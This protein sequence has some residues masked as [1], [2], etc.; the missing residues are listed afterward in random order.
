MRRILTAS[1]MLLS[2]A[3]LRADDR[4]V[5]FD[6]T[7]DFA[8]VKTFAIHETKVTSSR[9]ELSNALFARQI[10]DAVRQALVTKGLKE[11]SD[12]PDVVVET[13]VTGID[14][15]IGTAG[16]AN[17]QPPNAPPSRFGPVAF[18]E[19]T[20]VVDLMMG[21]PGKLIWH[22]VYRR[23]RESAAKLAE[24]M[25]EDATKLLSEY[26]PKKK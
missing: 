25:P 12:H 26:P 13:D 3:A 23:P 10:G 19:G 6:K 22:G 2:A 4:S 5:T 8:T 24:K 11:K 1:V 21:E 7:L 9:P 14:Y 16:R 20:L 17:P 18:T 15:V